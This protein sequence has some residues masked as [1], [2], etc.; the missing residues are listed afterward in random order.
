MARHNEMND[1]D[2]ARNYW[3]MVEQDGM[4]F[5]NSKFYCREV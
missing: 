4:E 1:V 3:K 5:V 2:E